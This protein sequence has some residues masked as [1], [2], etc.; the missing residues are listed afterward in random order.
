MKEMQQQYNHR[1]EKRVKK[2]NT[3]KMRRGGGT[4]E[5]HSCCK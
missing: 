3:S 2:T 1:D 4:S 5:C